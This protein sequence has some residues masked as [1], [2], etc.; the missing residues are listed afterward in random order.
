MGGSGYRIKVSPIL[1]PGSVA[2]GVA[3]PVGDLGFSWPRRAVAVPQP[4]LRC[5]AVPCAGG[6]V[7]RRGLAV[8][9]QTAL[10]SAPSVPRTAPGRRCRVSRRASPQR[11][12]S[13]AVD[14]CGFCV[15]SKGGRARRKPPGS[16]IVMK[17][18][19]DPEW[20]ARLRDYCRLRRLL[21][22]SADSLA[23]LSPF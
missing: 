15:G 8:S 6:A 22:S 11:R 5:A 4:L 14:G 12:S 10:G 19:I 16:R 1:F 20:S 21:C 23:V 18:G 3:V 17:P 9:L 7:L 2:P 13:G